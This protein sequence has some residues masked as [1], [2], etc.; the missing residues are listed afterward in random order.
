MNKTV[1][2]F[3]LVF[4]FT[5]QLIHAQT[6]GMDWPMVDGFSE[7][8]GH[9]DSEM[10]PPFE[11][12][13][14][15]DVG[16]NVSEFSFVDGII[17]CSY[18]TPNGNAFRA[19]DPMSNRVLWDRVVP[20]SRGGV[21]FVPAVSDDIVYI[22]GQGGTGLYALNRMT[23][24]S[25]WFYANQSLYGRNVAIKGDKLF[26][27]PPAQGLV[28]LDKDTGEKLWEFGSGSAQTVPLVDDRHV[29][30]T[31]RI[32][33]TLFAVTHDGEESW[34]YL[35]PSEVIDFEATMSIGD[36]ILVKTRTNLIALDQST[37]QEIWNTT[38]MDSNSYITT[39][40]ALTY[41]PK[42]LL[43]HEWI[44]DWSDTF[45]I[46]GFD[47]NGNMIWNHVLEPGSGGPAVSF[48]NYLTQANGGDL[49]IR[50]AMD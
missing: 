13:T 29:Y 46:Q 27:Q 11:L 48:G 34:K 47:Y 12:K 7:R 22:G 50:H 44:G 26:L 25:I 31:S 16:V 28:C 43:V 42:M 15:V 10:T 6:P 21:N 14:S 24:D 23:G 17:Y 39:S 30:F 37:G 3:A 8:T 33:D 45:M 41:T 1:F 49:E 38:L 2:Q 5:I 40:N 9:V 32:H 36:T 20:R 19:Y 4:I 18:S 35:L